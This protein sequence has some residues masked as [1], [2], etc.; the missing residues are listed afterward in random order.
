MEHIENLEK[1]LS[2]KNDVIDVLRK[3]KQIKAE[4]TVRAQTVNIVSI[5]MLDI[6][7][8]QYF[9]LLAEYIIRLQELASLS[10]KSTGQSKGYETKIKDIEGAMEERKHT[11]EKIE[12]ARDAL[13]MQLRNL[14]QTLQ[15]KDIQV[16]VSFLDDCRIRS[17]KRYC[18]ICQIL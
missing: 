13:T 12:I 1:E 10:E 14:E 7:V 9:V 3:E 4:E 2:N 18:F 17:S 11:L 16:E 15:E 8:E 5:K 6:H